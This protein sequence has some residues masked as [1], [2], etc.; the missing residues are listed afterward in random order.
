MHLSYVE[1]NGGKDDEALD[2]I[3][4]P[5]DRFGITYVL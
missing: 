5:F 1:Y 4:L 3:I 2:L